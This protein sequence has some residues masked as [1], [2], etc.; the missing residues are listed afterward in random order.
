[1]GDYGLAPEPFLNHAPFD[2]K[3]NCYFGDIPCKIL[4]HILLFRNS[5]DRLEKNGQ[6]DGLGTIMNEELDKCS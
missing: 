2:I 5:N 6:C 1:M 3:K 4:H